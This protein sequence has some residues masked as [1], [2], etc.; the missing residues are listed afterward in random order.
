MSGS[1]DRAG[2]VGPG[3]AVTS[4]DAWVSGEAGVS[5]EAVITRLRGAAGPSGGVDPAQIVGVAQRRRA[6]RGA[7]L[8]TLTVVGLVAGGLGVGAQVWSRGASQT[9]GSAAGAASSLEGEQDSDAADGVAGSAPAAQA[10]ERAEAGAAA[11]RAG[12]LGACPASVPAPRRPPA[13]GLG[14]WVPPTPPGARPEPEGGH[15]FD[16][17]SA[18]V[19]REAPTGSVICRYGPVRDAEMTPGESLPL[20]G[21][22]RVAQGLGQVPARLAPE[23]AAW[24]GA[25]T[26]RGGDVTVYLVGLGYG[27]SAQLWLSV[28]DD[29]NDCALPTNGRYVGPRPIG[30]RV[31]AAY[32]DRV[33]AGS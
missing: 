15:A 12:S 16:P 27:S 21:R 9:A 19:P 31:A 32:V 23:G 18:L 7:A 24:R 33:W 1:D 13:A 2:G 6:R 22:V 3:D 20:S 10:D 26:E 29:P 4:G 30:D 17:A 25:C 28:V 11:S 8:T 5:G 14:H